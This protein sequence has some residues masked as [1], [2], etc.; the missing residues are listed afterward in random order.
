[1]KLLRNCS[2]AQ[3]R[4]L[5]LFGIMASLVSAC[6][7]DTLN[8]TADVTGD[9]IKSFTCNPYDFPDF[10]PEGDGWVTVDCA[11]DEHTSFVTASLAVMD[12][13]ADSWSGTVASDDTDSIT[14]DVAVYVGDGGSYH[15]IECDPDGCAE[16]E[17]P[18]YQASSSAGASCVVALTRVPE[19]LFE[20]TSGYDLIEGS[21]SCE[22][23]GYVSDADEPDSSRTVNLLMEFWYE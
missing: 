2:F 8:F 10:E 22:R 19:G 14:G 7:N 9:M 3:S 23:M 21:I 20:S 6:G 5:V 11:N 17:E 12:L 1:M 18:A 16:W 13:D 15:T 4:K